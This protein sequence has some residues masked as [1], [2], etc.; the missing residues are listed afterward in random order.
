VPESSRRKTLTL[1]ED[2]YWKFAR[3]KA[4]LKARTWRE[5]ADKLVE[6]LEGKDDE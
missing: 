6:I 4:V 3:I 1:D 2:T 5:L